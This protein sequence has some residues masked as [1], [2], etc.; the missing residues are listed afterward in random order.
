MFGFKVCSGLWKAYHDIF[1]ASSLKHVPFA[2]LKNLLKCKVV[3][4]VGSFFSA[5]ERVK[6]HSVSTEYFLLIIN[7]TVF[8]PD[9]KCLIIT[10]VY[11]KII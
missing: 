6:A 8:I 3:C 4:P 9:W 2:V 11:K 1:K 7:P 10:K 5:K